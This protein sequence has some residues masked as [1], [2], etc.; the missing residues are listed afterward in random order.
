MVGAHSN[1]H[2]FSIRYKYICIC[3]L[4]EFLLPLE[5]GIVIGNFCQD[6]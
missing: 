4:V 6:L 3:E 1:M 5:H 2:P